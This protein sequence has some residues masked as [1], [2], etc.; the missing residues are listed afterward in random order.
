MKFYWVLFFRRLF[1]QECCFVKKNLVSTV[2]SAHV[3]RGAQKENSKRAVGAGFFFLSLK[4]PNKTKD[5]VK[6]K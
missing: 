1:R 6:H 3:F 4:E 5:V 2:S